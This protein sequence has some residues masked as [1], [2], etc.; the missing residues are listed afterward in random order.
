MTHLHPGLRKL[1]NMRR[2]PRVAVSFEDT[3]MHGPGL[4]EYFVAH[5]TVKFPPMDDPPPGM[6]MRIPV[7][8]VSGIAVS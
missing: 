6:R 3:E 7:D 1:E 2:D 5:G 4:K 8:R